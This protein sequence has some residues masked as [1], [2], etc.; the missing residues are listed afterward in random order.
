MGYGVR[1]GLK[2]AHACVA[3][4][5]VVLSHAS[6]S[7]AETQARPASAAPDAS[8]LARKAADNPYATR[9][10]EQ[11]I[12]V[13]AAWEQLDR[14]ERRWFFAEM[15]KRM[16]S[17]GPRMHTRMRTEVRFGRVFRNSEGSVVRIKAV[18]AVSSP[19]PAGRGER[20]SEIPA[21]EYGLGFERRRQESRQQSEA[22]AA[23]PATPTIPVKTSASDVRDSSIPLRL[24]GQPL[25]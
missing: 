25:P 18:R 7:W 5:V 23:A 12:K 14:V 19:H 13:T 8:E 3:V 11:F 22:D 9:S 21:K 6:R 10:N 15:R 1:T 4:V 17:D 16:A 2:P 20:T 24:R